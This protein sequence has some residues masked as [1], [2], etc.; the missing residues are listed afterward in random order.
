MI[1][2]VVSKNGFFKKVIHW[3]MTLERW[4]S[5]EPHPVDYFFEKA[6]F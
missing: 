5:R 3:Q 2:A 6:I 4:T 1:R